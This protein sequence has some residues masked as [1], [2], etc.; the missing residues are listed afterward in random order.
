MHIGVGIGGGGSQ[1]VLSF[2]EE[3]R[4]VKA[5]ES[6]GVHSVW[7]AEGWARDVITPLAYLAGVTDRIKLGTGIMQ[8]LSRSPAMIA[9]TAMSMANMSNNRFCLG[10]G[11]SGPQVMEGL[12]GV[13]FSSPLKRLKECIEILELAFSGKSLE[14]LG[15][16]FQLPLPDGAAGKPL[17]IDQSVTERV[18]I[19]VA[20]LGPKSLEYAGSHADGWLA[21][22]FVPEAADA[23]LTYVLQGLEKSSRPTTSLDIH[24]GGNLVFGDDIDQIIQQQKPQIAFTIGAMGSAKAN[25]YKDAYCRAGYAKAAEQIQKLWL[26]GDRRDAIESVPDELVVRTN[27]L[28]SSSDILQRV[29]AY[30]KSGVTTLR[31]YPVGDTLDSRI[32]ALERFMNLLDDAVQATH[33]QDSPKV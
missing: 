3:V 26:K 16:Q 29:D 2:S 19:Y 33:R 7:A 24:A 21:T 31:V 12:H 11:V 27:L 28:G 9:M 8:V 17:R 25:F 14:Y 10:L 13:R 5:A 6:L 22:A 20:A 30:R 32:S 18:P 15:D 1:A 4:Y 23:Q